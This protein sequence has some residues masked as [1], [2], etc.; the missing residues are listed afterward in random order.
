MS[1]EEIV[2]PIDPDKIVDNPGLVEFGHHVGSAA[3]VPADKSK[4]LGRSMS[5]MQEQTDM[6]LGQLKRQMEA[7][8]EEA[9]QIHARKE[10]SERIYGIKLGFKPV[11]SKLYYLYQREDL[12]HMLSLIAPS[13][14]G[15]SSQPSF[16]ACVKLLSDYTW[17]I[18]EKNEDLFSEF[19]A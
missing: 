18:L 15:R 11:I 2:N 5:S 19:M 14:W 1:K 12:S 13:E 4:L 16:I 6:Q 7:L 17:D 10:I 8:I 3:I 9:K